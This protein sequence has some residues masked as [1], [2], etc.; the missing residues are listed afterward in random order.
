MTVPIDPDTYALL[1]TVQRQHDAIVSGMYRA[2]TR[3]PREDIG[4]LARDPE[5]V[6]HL[7]TVEAI[8]T[9]LEAHDNG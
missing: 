1:G 4:E 7:D 2:W 9:Y 8:A 3:D 5:L 6:Y